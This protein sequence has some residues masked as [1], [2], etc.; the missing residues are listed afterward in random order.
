MNETTKI[1]LKG[2]AGLVIVGGLFLVARTIIKKV[3]KKKVDEAED[4]LR[5]TS[6]SVSA[7][8]SSQEQA[9]NYNPASDVKKIGDMIYG[10]NFY[11][12]TAEVN[13]I[14]VPMSDARLRKLASAYKKKYG[15]SLYKNLTGECCYNVY[16]S[17]EN[18][19]KSLGL[20]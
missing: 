17:S 14:I 8:T 1:I 6:T 12:Y 16:T 10:N 11:Q 3:K 15:I 5:E 19:L 20:T 13:A 2:V 9:D 18:R 7:N 4:K